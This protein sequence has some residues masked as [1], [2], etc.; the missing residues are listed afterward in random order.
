MYSLASFSLE[1]ALISLQQNTALWAMRRIKGA[2]TSSSAQPARCHRNLPAG[3]PTHRPTRFGGLW[4]SECARCR[5][6]PNSHP[7]NYLWRRYFEL[8]TDN[9]LNCIQNFLNRA[10]FSR[11]FFKKLLK[12]QRNLC[13][14]RTNMKGYFREIR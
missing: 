11:M 13:L 10:V 14:C 5:F 1:A 6:K 4:H 9:L 3:L 7:R 2:P 8:L 12:K